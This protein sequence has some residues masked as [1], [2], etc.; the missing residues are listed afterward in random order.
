VSRRLELPDDLFDD[1]RQRALG[2][3]SIK[4]MTSMLE[5][6]RRIAGKFLSGEWGAELAGAE[7]GRT[8]DRRLAEERARVRRP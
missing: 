4:Q 8:E 6:R 7:D 2:G 3:A 1:I 5:E